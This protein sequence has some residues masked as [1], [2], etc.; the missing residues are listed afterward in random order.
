[1]EKIVSDF[2]ERLAREHAPTFLVLG[3]NHL[4]MGTRSDVF[5]DAILSK[6]EFVEEASGLGYERI[7]NTKIAA[8]IEASRAWISDRANLLVPPA[9][10]ETVAEY[11][12]SGVYTS[13]F[14]GLL[15]RVFRSDWRE[16]QP[17][18]SPDLQPL[19]PRNRTN[20]HI[21]YLY[22]SIE[23][24]ERS[25]ASPLDQFDVTLR[26]PLV[27]TLLQRLPESVTP[28]GT[29][30]IDA[31]DPQTDWL[32]PQKLIPILMALEQGQAYLFSTSV[33]SITNIFLKRA[34]SEGKL[35]V[36]EQSL[37]AVLL[38]GMEFGIIPLG[39]KVHISSKARVIELSND[40][41]IVDEQL[42]NQVSRFGTIL[43]S[44]LPGPRKA[45]SP[46]KRYSEFRTF[47]A[48]SGVRPIWNAFAQGLPFER[49]CEYEL[50]HEVNTRLQGKVFNSDPVIL[51]GQA[52]SGKTIT[53][54]SIALKV[55]EEKK[56]P[57]VFIARRSQ[58]FNY[59]DLDS[60]C[61]WAEENGFSATFVV[62]DG[63]QEL[64][65]YNVLHKY[66]LG[67]GR[68]FVLLASSY[69]VDEDESL[70]NKLV[71][72][73]SLL[74]VSEIPRFKAHL[75][76]F[77]PTLGASLDVFLKDGDASFL[78][79]LYRLLPESRSQ[80][81]KGL[82][83]EAGAAAVLIR[84]K[85]ELIKPE[86][87]S[88]TIL[89]IALEKAGMLADRKFLPDE[90]TMVAGEWLYAEQELIGLILVPGQFGLQVP[91][92]VLLRSISR[93]A[94]TNFHTIIEGIDLFRWSEDSMDNI[95]LGVRHALE[96][97]IIAQ[98]RLGGPHAEIEYAIKLL[99]NV[100][101]NLTRRETPEVQFAADL[102]YN[103]GPK[104][105]EKKLYAGHYLELAN[106]LAGIRE[107]NGVQSIRLMLQESSL[108]REAIVLN[109]IVESDLPGR[110]SL[111][112]RAESVLNDAV[113]EINFSKKT[114]RLN[115]MLLNELASIYGTRAR[116][117]IR[118]E[119]SVELV[120]EQFYKAKKIAMSA[121]GLMPE[122][123]FPIDVI[124]WCTKDVLKHASLDEKD[125]LEIVASIFNVFAL[126]DGDEISARDK[127]MLERRRL[128]F[129]DIL[130]DEVLKQDSLDALVRLGSTAGFYLQAVGIAG[131]LPSSDTTLDEQKLLQYRKAVDY[132]TENYD[133]IKTDGR[134]LYLYLRYWWSSS[135]K[136]PFFPS[137]RT[138]VPFDLERWAK[139]LDIL[140]NLISIGEEYATPSILYL[141]AICKWQ[142]GYHDDAL[143]L[144][145]ELQRLSDRVTGRRRVLKTYLASD[146]LGRP[147][148]YHGT[149]LW[150]SPDGSKG[151]I[152]VEGIRQ[153]VAFFPRDFKIDEISKDEKVSDFHIAFNYIAPT[154][155]PAYHYTVNS[156]V[157]K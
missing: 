150:V 149:V 99:S 47:L 118:A 38:Q 128:E 2:C 12:W 27:S 129:S 56:Y 130:G 133:L 76:S 19:D 17:I 3:Q 25:H 30:V 142:L 123:F 24:S 22:G 82:N 53:L 71:L 59:A 110:L 144:W 83:L 109:L 58:R 127:E 78:V 105:P 29:L 42:W 156:G 88:T 40:E 152:F 14:D 125:R 89:G 116:E 141:Q 44:N 108:L 31:Y 91:I 139:A 33:D 115:G 81:R 21:T 140:E 48:E 136:L 102:I 143:E 51:H 107:N 69:K 68:K 98:S 113:K 148:K 55:H 74:S 39:K 20:L 49:D 4:R 84:N 13:T 132:L 1:M 9:W 32:Q 79:A 126:C 35:Q 121:R 90:Q 92:E 97:K 86:T 120:L 87:A 5:L 114:A 18:T 131:G 73:P 64:E 95:S 34:I 85:S 70:G 146:A 10:L 104:G 41:V 103:L 52:G 62:W 106:A 157:R 57:V 72:S 94:V 119:E 8:N 96:A 61:Q 134:C 101:Q 122:D 54:A 153:R 15:N 93:S 145:R 37:A 45:H 117:Y 124:A 46:E 77:E 16:V 112:E 6:Y 11:A 75:S 67:R 135:S 36:F 23:R 147:I 63:M 7:F 151:E 154:A 111:L 43:D 60:F 137:E 66:L 100:R 155:D 138:A 65:Q 50:L 28:F 80:V 26:D